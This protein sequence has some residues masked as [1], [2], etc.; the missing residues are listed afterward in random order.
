M[1]RIEVLVPEEVWKAW[2][3]VSFPG[4]EKDKGKASRRGGTER[5]WF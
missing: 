2:I 4:I 1:P 3:V 5:T